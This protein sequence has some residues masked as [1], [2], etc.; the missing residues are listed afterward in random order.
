LAARI[1]SGRDLSC[2]GLFRDDQEI[3][4]QCPGSLDLLVLPRQAAAWLNNSLGP[5]RWSRCW[6]GAIRDPRCPVDV[7]DCKAGV[8]N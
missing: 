4:G 3:A 7:A 6:C 5:D 1:A 2:H 8:K